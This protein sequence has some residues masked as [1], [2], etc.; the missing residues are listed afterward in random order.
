[1]K[2]F[3]IIL[4]FL[5]VSFSTKAQT[6]LSQN[7]TD[8]II[9]LFLNQVNQDSIKNYI[10][11]LQSFST[12]YYRCDSTKKKVAEWV[13]SK[14]I[15]FGYTNVVI[16]SFFASYPPIGS[17]Q[18]NVISSLQGNIN[19]DKVLLI[20]AHHDSRSSNSNLPSPGT[21]DNASGVAGVLESARII[22]KNNYIAPLT[23]KFVTFAA[24]EGG[25]HGSKDYVKK[26][27]SVGENIKM[28]IN[29]DMISYFPTDTLTNILIM[30]EWIA[31]NGTWLQGFAD[32]IRSNYTSLTPYY[33]YG[34]PNS[35][36]YYFDSHGYASISLEENMI[37]YS[38]NPYFHTVNDSIKYCNIDYCSQII[39]VAL[40]MLLK[41]PDTLTSVKE[42]STFDLNPIFIFP[43]P[44]TNDLTIESPQTAII[45]I[46]NI[47]GQ[48]ILQRQLQQ[49]K[50]DIDISGLAKELY[51]L[52]LFSSGKTE[53]AKFVKE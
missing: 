27:D 3:L 7:P 20:G 35:D 1:M 50:T 21:D 34:L 41:A 49:G 32:S 48:T 9:N 37:E 24:E 18:Y 14:F 33:L 12:R 15:S 36:N 47:Q 39:K 51:I 11:E 25:G 45:E 38:D 53:V 44:A 43:N 10:T 2:T 23:I 40:G 26:A 13:Q 52:K 31:P 22:K 28:M 42:Y 30:N 19:P 29:L 6:A 16:D 4:V 46:L 17:W 8:S 5:I